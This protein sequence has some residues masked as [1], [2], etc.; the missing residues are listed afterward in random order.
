MA[1]CKNCGKEI[2]DNAVIC[3]NCG[4]SQKEELVTATTDNGGFL[5]I[6]IFSLL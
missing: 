3:P 5:W 4:V 1:F 6:Q 2:D